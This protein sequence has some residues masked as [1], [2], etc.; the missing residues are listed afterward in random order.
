MEITSP[1]NE[2]ATLPPPPPPPPFPKS[3][4]LV[5]PPITS[6]LKNKDPF[7]ISRYIKLPN[8]TTKSIIAYYKDVDPVL[9]DGPSCGLVALSMASQFFD[10]KRCNADKILAKAKSMRFTKNGEMF[11]ARNMAILAESLLGCKATVVSDVFENKREILSCICRGCPVLFPYDA[12]KNHQPC[13]NNGRNAHWALLNGLC[14]MTSED[15]SDSGYE[16]W[17]DVDRAYRLNSGMEKYLDS[18]AQTHV[19]AHQGKSRHMALWD[20]EHLLSSN[21]NMFEVTAKYSSENMV[22]PDGDDVLCELRYKA[23]LLESGNIL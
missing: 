11:S 6:L 21:K 1:D 14:F 18:S 19:F 9:Q 10:G 8:G 5:S 15:L 17:G 2:P 23:V 4:Q 3:T 13:L 7:P 22:L 12:D 20:F 16:R